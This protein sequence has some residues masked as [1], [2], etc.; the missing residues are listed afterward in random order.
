MTESAGD[1][2]TTYKVVVNQEQQYSIWPERKA[3]PLG[4]SDVG[5]SGPKADCLAHIDTVWVDMRPRSLREAMEQDERAAA[6]GH[7]ADAS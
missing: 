5:V 6:G 2:A 4:W 3:M 1:D 7:Q